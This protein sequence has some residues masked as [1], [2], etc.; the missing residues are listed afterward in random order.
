[1]PHDYYM[2]I[3]INIAE[4]AKHERLAFFKAPVSICLIIV[5]VWSVQDWRYVERV[6]QINS[7]IALADE[8]AL[9]Y[10]AKL[11]VTSPEQ[12]FAKVKSLHDNLDK[13][14][15]TMVDIIN[16]KES[17]NNIPI[18]HPSSIVLTMEGYSLKQQEQVAKEIETCNM[19]QTM[20]MLKDCKVLRDQIRLIA[21]IYVSSDDVLT[22][23]T[24]EQIVIH[25]EMWERFESRE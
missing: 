10:E 4:H 18:Y 23:G 13:V 15:K 24:I 5:C 1:M 19:T 7:R 20:E 22:R 21:P 3:F 14:K 9:L 8:R 25:N 17:L 2:D 12:A 6:D 11:E 16:L